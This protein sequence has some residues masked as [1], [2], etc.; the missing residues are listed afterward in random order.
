MKDSDEFK[1]WY[2]SQYDMESMTYSATMKIKDFR[3]KSSRDKNPGL[4]LTN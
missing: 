2:E 4:P 3:A 1:I